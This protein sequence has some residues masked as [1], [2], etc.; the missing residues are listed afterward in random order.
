LVFG[1]RP[2]IPC[3]PAYSSDELRGMVL[4]FSFF[5]IDGEGD[6]MLTLFFPL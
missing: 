6:E 2:V 4:F 1:K 5:S 3:L